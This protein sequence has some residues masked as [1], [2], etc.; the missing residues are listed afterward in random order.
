VSHASTPADVLF[1]TALA[2]KATAQNTRL[3][4]DFY[5]RM[6]AHHEAGGSA[7]SDQ[8]LRRKLD[9]SM[10]ETG[11]EMLPREIPDVLTLFNQQ[12]N[13]ALFSPSGAAMGGRPRR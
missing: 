2:T 4:W 11:I 3:L 1:K 9:D 7:L 5:D 6:V 8:A 10:R 12:I 13:N